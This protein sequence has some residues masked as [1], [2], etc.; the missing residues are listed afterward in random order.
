MTKIVNL[1]GPQLESPVKK[2]IEFVKALSSEGFVSGSSSKPE[3]WKNIS[4]LIQDGGQY[5]VM[6]AW[7]DSPNDGVVYLGHWN[8]G[9]VG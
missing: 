9:V 6:L 7:D 4:L 8:D 5:E 2:P 3:N 1:F